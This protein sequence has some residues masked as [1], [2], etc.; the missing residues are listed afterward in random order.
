MHKCT[1]VKTNILKIINALY[2]TYLPKA[3]SIYS[4]LLGTHCSHIS[5]CFS[6]PIWLLC[7]VDYCHTQQSKMEPFFPARQRLTD[8]SFVGVLMFP[9]EKATCLCLPAPQYTA[10]SPAHC[11]CERAELRNKRLW[12]IFCILFFCFFFFFRS[13]CFV[14]GGMN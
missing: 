12:F 6:L 11:P 14:K 10:S 9:P 1:H 2:S 4:S 5:L 3:L 7:S 13:G 8:E